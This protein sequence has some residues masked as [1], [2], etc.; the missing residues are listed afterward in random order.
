MIKKILAIL[1][2][3][4]ISVSF[5]NTSFADDITNNEQKQKEIIRVGN[6]TKMR[7]K[8]F[9]TMWGGTTS[10][11]DVQRLIHGYA[12][13]KYDIDKTIYR[14]NKNVVRGSSATY[15]TKGNKIYSIVLYDDLFY[16]DGTPVTAYDYAF[17]ILFSIDKAIEETGGINKDY[18]WIVGIDEYSS[19]ET[20][21]LAGVKVINEYMLRI[22]AKAESLPYFYELERLQIY[23]YPSFVIA[24]YTSV[25]DDGDGIY[26]ANPL[27]PAEIRKTVLDTET[28]YLSH[29]KV[30]T[31][32]Y[33]LDSYDGETAFFSIN[34]YYKGNEA[35]VLPVIDN[36]EYTTAYN[37]DMIDNLENGEFDLLN[38]VTEKEAIKQGIKSQRKEDK[39]ITSDSYKR[40]GL[41]MLWFP[42][43]SR[44][45]QELFVRKAIAYCFD[46][47]NFIKDYTGTF[48][49][50]VDGLYG[51]GQW[52]YLLASQK[53]NPP[54]SKSLPEDEYAKEINEYKDLNLEGLTK[55][56]LDMDKASKL[57]NKA[58]W[59]KNKDN[60]RERI[61]DNEE[62]EILTIV[63][64]IPNTEGLEEYLDQYLI[65]NLEKVGIKTKVQTLS[66]EELQMVYNGEMNGFDILYLGENFTE[67]LNICILKPVNNID[68][69]YN[70]D[71]SLT[72]VK[73][74]IYQ[75]AENMVKTKPTDYKSFLGK[76]ITMQEAISELLPMVPVYSNIYFDFYNNKIHSYKIEDFATWTEAIIESYIGAE[77]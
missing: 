72:F 20:N 76:W 59:K 60:Q 39:H 31:G 64:G 26:L 27:D 41:T 43:S 7:G 12:L 25:K 15:D 35:G 16:S 61:I 32:A 69:T 40:T 44:I 54:V 36:I 6:P 18:S 68:E 56:E 62:T 29:P 71:N 46:R 9:T 14:Y 65:G 49:E 22:T 50:K 58:G 48:G 24:P 2:V 34:K 42:E 10:D 55:Y 74:E 17:T 45:V 8:F 70:Q 21:T 75:L 57:L 3:M 73:E 63:I 23:P 13:T 1:L 52:M 53:M 38:K 77:E 37:K 33:V 4:V 19:R 51:I 30:V 67:S 5:I 66:T 28:G 11:L 47:E